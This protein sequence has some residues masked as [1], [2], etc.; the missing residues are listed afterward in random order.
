MTEHRII[1][2]DCLDVLPT[3]ERESV[4]LVIADPPYNIGIDYGAGAKADRRDDYD[5]W[6]ERWIGW[7]YRALKPTGSLWVISGQEYGAYIDIAIRNAGMTIRNRITW[8]ETF[9][10]YCHNKFGRT[11]RPIYYATKSPKSFTF[12]K[13]AV[14]V[15]SARQEKIGRAHV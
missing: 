8:H 6:C 15:P 12:N 13:D 2:G 1:Q 10:V 14:T 7:C 4:D 3:L 9:G 5:I 11:S